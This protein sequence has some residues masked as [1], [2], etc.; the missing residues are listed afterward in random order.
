MIE[1]LS[2]LDFVTVQTLGK[3]L[4]EEFKRLSKHYRAKQ[5]LAK[6]EQQTNQHLHALDKDVVDSI[7][8]YSVRAPH[9]QRH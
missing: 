1:S 5:E 9:R 4:H 3:P 8:A 7:H 2:C 6:R